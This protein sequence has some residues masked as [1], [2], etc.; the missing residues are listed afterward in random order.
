MNQKRRDHSLLLKWNMKD[1]LKKLSFGLW[2]VLLL[3]CHKPAKENTEPETQRGSF[4]FQ[5]EHLV[6]KLPLRPDSVY[7]NGHGE[8]F[9]VSSLR[10]YV[11]NITLLRED[12]VRVPVPESYYL[13]DA[14]EVNNEGISQFAVPNIPTGSYKGVSYMVGVDSARNVAG[15][16]SGA[17]DPIQD[18]FWSWTT[19]YIFFKL[20]GAS[21][22]SAQPNRIFMYHI[23]GFRSPYVGS[24]I[25]EHDFQG[26]TIAINASA[27]PVIQERVNLSHFFTTPNTIKIAEVSSFMSIN[28]KTLEFASNCRSMFQFYNVHN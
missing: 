16:Q 18:M 15:A 24:F 25:V 21:P 27:S 5:F 22:V 4:Y 10:Y 26:G 28:S 3:S 13:V 17:L 6:D 11:S 8:Q 14:F 19:G 1:I 7:T 2:A 23:G 9:K 12:G 20:E